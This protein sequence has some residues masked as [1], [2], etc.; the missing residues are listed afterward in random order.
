[1]KILLLEDDYNL[2]ESL[3]EILELEGYEVNIASSAKEAYEKTFNKNYDLYIFDINL[4]DENGIEILKNLRFAG[5]ET[6]TIYITALTDID[7]MAKAFE[8]GAEDFIKKPFEVEEL[9]IRLKAKFNTKNNKIKIKDIT[10]NPLTKEIRKNG[11]IIPLGDTLKNIF[12]ELATNLNKIVPK[13]RLLDYTSEKSLRVNI[14][15]LKNKLGLEIKNIRGEGYTIE[16]WKKIY[17]YK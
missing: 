10:Y 5:D 7:T 14:N 8:S 3:K 15:K 16:I 13:E 6:P 17:I 9:L 4:P 1:M 2:A 12:H 11:K